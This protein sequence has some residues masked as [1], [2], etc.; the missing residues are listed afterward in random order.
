MKFIEKNTTFNLLEV[1]LWKTAS[2]KG[3]IEV[4]YREDKFLFGLYDMWSSR[5]TS[6]H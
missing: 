3:Q 2:Y 5:K 1:F 4:Y 6:L